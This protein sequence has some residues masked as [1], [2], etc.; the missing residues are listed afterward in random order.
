MSVDLQV[1]LDM[2]TRYVNT[3]DVLSANKLSECFESK[4]D[5]NIPKR[6]AAFYKI[7]ACV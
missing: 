5:Y 1:T 7:S 4:A 3:V 6:I 2:Y